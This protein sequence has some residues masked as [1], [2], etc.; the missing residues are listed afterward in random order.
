[1]EVAGTTISVSLFGVACSGYAVIEF[2]R[3]FGR[4]ILVRFGQDSIGKLFGR[5]LEDFLWGIHNSRQKFTT[6][7][8]F[9]SV[10]M[11]SF[12]VLIQRAKLRGCTIT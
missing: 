7:R 8:K 4:K 6:P 3:D 11:P 1:M 12:T 2:I 5:S 10:G 9:K